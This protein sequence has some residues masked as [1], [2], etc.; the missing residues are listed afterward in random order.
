[1]NVKMNITP[2]SLAS[3]IDHTLLKPESSSMEIEQLC[4][5]A[6][7]FKFA[8]VCINP[9]YLRLAKD[10]L[11]G[12]E[13]KVCTVVGFPLGAT[14]AESKVYEAKDAISNGAQEIDMVLNVGRLKSQDYGYVENEISAVVNVAHS[15]RVIVK[16]IIETCLLSDGEKEKACLIVENAGA[17]FV[18]TSTGFSKGGATV[19][20]VALIRRVVGNRIGVKAAGGIRTYADAAAMI[21]AG[22]SRIGTSSGVKIIREAKQGNL[23]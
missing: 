7:E 19:A 6:V 3:M 22:A 23:R 21:Q 15:N 16:V 2:E 10:R 14:T 4:R 13:V 5:E 20:D 11:E 8:S 18:K 12:A 9:S 1:M 17:D